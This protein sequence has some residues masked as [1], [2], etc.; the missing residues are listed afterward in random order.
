MTT[1][2]DMCADGIAM[3]IPGHTCTY[4][5]PAGTTLTIKKGIKGIRKILS[6][7]GS[8]WHVFLNNSYSSFEPAT[9]T[10]VRKAYGAYILTGVQG[11]M[12]SFESKYEEIDDDNYG[13]CGWCGKECGCK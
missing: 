12:L 13:I 3:V 10:E 2:C 7:N 5:H 6:E 8:D 4:T 11:N 1:S 9:L